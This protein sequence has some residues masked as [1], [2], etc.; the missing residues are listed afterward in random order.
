MP[1]LATR[2]AA[3]ELATG[4]LA[5]LLFSVGIFVRHTIAARAPADP[6]SGP[7]PEAEAAGNPI[8]TTWTLAAPDD[9]ASL[10]SAL[11]AAGISLTE[12]INVF[13]AVV[14][15]GSDGYLSRQYEAGGGAR[16]DDFWPASSIKVLAAV[17]ALEFLA[18]LGFTG[19]AAVAFDDGDAWTVRDLYDAA[20]IESSNEAYDRLVQIAG[21]DWLNT[22]FLT[23]ENGL[24]A[25][26]IQKSYIDLGILS[27]PGMTISE[28]DRS[29]DLPARLPGGDLGVPEEGNRSDL[30]ELT[31]SVARLGFGDHL[32][33]DRRFGIDPSDRAALAEALLQ[34]EGFLRPGA[35]AVLGDDVLVYEKPGHVEGAHCVSVGYIRTPGHPESFMLGVS[36]PDDGPECSTLA[37]IASAALGFL[38]TRL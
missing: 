14:V 20:I 34:A 25:T 26:V 27:S 33:E 13:A 6:S 4:I 5:V 9:N 17:G 15:A 36:T 12:G 30:F 11:E 1:G 18:G 29:L 28:G 19:S 23:S 16:A 32:P 24:A 3:W 21:V 8:A 10:R 31:E 37:A 38:T 35:A 7:Q 2:R 22:E